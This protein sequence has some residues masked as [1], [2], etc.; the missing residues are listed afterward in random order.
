MIREFFAYAVGFTGGV[1][2]AARDVNGDGRADIITGAGPGGGP[3][4]RVFDGVTGRPI[5][6]FFAYAVGF[7]GGVFVAARDVNG[8]GRADIITG[9]GPGGGPHVRVFDGATG[10]VI[11]EFFAYALGFT[12]GVLVGGH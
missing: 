7:T 2:V 12:G 1:F 10:A 5:R 6:E 9:A 4:V 11:R 3:H 8:D